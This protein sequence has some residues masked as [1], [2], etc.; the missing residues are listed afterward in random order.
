[1]QH[2]FGATTGNLYY[3]LKITSGTSVLDRTYVYYYLKIQ[4]V[5][6]IQSL[7]L[8]TV[9][10]PIVLWPLKLENGPLM[11]TKVTN[12]EIWKEPFS[13]HFCWED[14]AFLFSMKKNPN[15]DTTENTEKQME[16]ISREVWRPKIA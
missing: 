15:K 3:T 1:M 14:L 16:D 4:L 2:F 13:D 8:P 7:N 5:R 6:L 10:D 11:H 9:I 12:L